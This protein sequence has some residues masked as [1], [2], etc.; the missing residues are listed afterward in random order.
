MARATFQPHTLE[1]TR[2]LDPSGLDERAADRLRQEM[3]A[4]GDDPIIRRALATAEAFWPRILWRKWR[5]WLRNIIVIAAKAPGEPESGP[6]RV[7]EVT[8]RYLVEP[9]EQEGYRKS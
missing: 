7:E 2:E 6:G 5:Q 8:T 3:F 4:G 9:E 1:I